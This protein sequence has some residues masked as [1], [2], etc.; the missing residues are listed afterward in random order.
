MKKNKFCQSCGMPL[1]KD[2]SQHG[3]KNN[4]EKSEKFCHFCYKDGKFNLAE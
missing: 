3:T 4:G 2:L 1:K